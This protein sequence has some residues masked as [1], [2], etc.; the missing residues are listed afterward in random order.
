MSGDA[1]FT[2]AIREAARKTGRGGMHG[3]AVALLLAMVCHASATVYQVGPAEPYH[4][5]FSVASLLQPGDVV[6]VDGNVT[7][8]GGVVFSNNGA[9]GNP[10]TIQGI[11]VDGARPVLAQTTG[12]N[13]T[14]GAVVNITGS[15]YVME[16][17]DLTQGGDPHAGAAFYSSGD[18]VTLQDS[19]VH[20]CTVTGIASSAGAGSLT[21]DYVEVYHCGAGGTGNQIYAQSNLTAYPAAVFHM[22]FCYIHNGNGGD[23]VKSRVPRTEIY[24]NW[25]EGAYSHEL[26]L[27]GADPGAQAPGAATEVQGVA[28]VVGNVLL[29]D[30]GSHGMVANI[31][32]SVG[33]TNGRYRFVSNTAVMSSSS[34][35]ANPVALQLTDQVQSIEVYNN[36]FYGAGGAP[37]AVLST[38]NLFP[39]SWC[40]IVG[41][42]NFT[43][44]GSTLIPATWT[45]N[46]TGPDPQVVNAAANHFTPL[47]GGAL[48]GAGAN[49]TPDPPGLPFP[50]PLATPQ[51][52]PPAQVAYALNGA[53]PRAPNIPIDIGAYAVPAPPGPGYTLPVAVNVPVQLANH[54][55]VTIAVLANDT[56]AS[57]S[58]LSIEAAGA[59]GAG[60]AAI[61]GANVVY[62]LSPAFSG[63]DSFTY[64]ITDGYGVATATV[65][66]TYSGPTLYQVGPTEPYPDLESV[67]PLVMPGDVVQVDG[68]ATYPGGLTFRNSGTA[69]NKI[70]IQGIRINGNRPV[71][72]KVTDFVGPLGAVV[73]FLGSHYVME[74]FDITTGGDPNAGRAFYNVAD[75]I[76]LADSVVHDSPCTG[77]SGSDASGSLTLLYDEIYNCGAGTQAHQ[78]YV[79]SSN[80]LYPNAV[81]NMEF[82]YLHNGAGGNNIKSR[83]ARTEI[84]YNWIEGA[85]YHEFDLDGADPSGQAPGAAG[86]V[87]EVGDVVGNV[88]VK[89]ANSKGLV[90]NVGGDGT[91]WSDGRYRFVNNTI[92]LPTTLIYGEMMF[93]LKNAVQSIEIYNNLIYRF[94]GGP[95][96]M[97]NT[98]DWYINT[99]AKVIGSNNWIPPHSALIPAGLTNNLTGGNPDVANPMAFNF[100]PLAGGV[101]AGA[102]A[103]TTPDPPG[104]PFPS[105]LATPLFC[106]RSARRLSH[107]RCCATNGECSH[108]HRRIRSADGAVAGRV[109]APGRAE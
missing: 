22:A 6:Q 4:D 94:G 86:L 45:N 26:D 44:Q 62:T 92:I 43:P 97:V 8:A 37:M 23:N 95:V 38:A 106:P 91:G 64:S 101:L 108:R 30:P 71:I 93:Q 42:N 2:R 17:F 107:K 102:G 13:G 80:T 29:K 18:D 1:G 33:W 56:D 10:I 76:T 27:D 96:N 68:D 66:L 73:R 58:Q 90:A 24:Y 40:M 49:S 31:G 57:G 81:F 46:V 74:G 53:L 51:Y 34:A 89:D 98:V 39:G 19:A 11:A 99:P 77:I 100:T 52:L 3:A 14:G 105:P 63:S 54:L 55:P 104:L 28:D 25:I 36:L 5:L 75:D 79:A 35:V 48:A 59:G 72:S 85:Y 83:V 47:A 16:G 88:I 65:T 67:A 61:S 84:Y 60:T 70:V 103:T 9:A 82:C 15:H 32:D 50:S 78:V 109:L 69:A 12:F 87:R 20:D 41:S 21:L 7:Y